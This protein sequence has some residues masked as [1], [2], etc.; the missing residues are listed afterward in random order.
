MSSR[1]FTFTA[2]FQTVEGE[3]VQ[4]RIREIPGVITVAPTRAEAEELLIDAFHEYMLAGAGE[5][6]VG[7]TGES[8]TGL[9]VA[10]GL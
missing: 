6:E 9:K 1:E 2:V 4:A 3:W 7:S 5:V 10:V 8:E